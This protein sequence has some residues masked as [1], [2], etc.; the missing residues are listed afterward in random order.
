MTRNKLFWIAKIFFVVAFNIVVLSFLWYRYSTLTDLPHDI[1]KPTRA[2]LV[3]FAISDVVF[4]TAI[5]L[6]D[7]SRFGKTLRR[8][9]L[10]LLCGIIAFLLVSSPFPEAHNRQGDASHMQA[11]IFVAIMGVIAG[12]YLGDYLEKRKQNE[13]Q[14]PK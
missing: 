5:V 14:G 11:S 3:L 8:I 9:G 4:S 1:R 6:I 2:A 12:Y 10:M 13:R 7:L